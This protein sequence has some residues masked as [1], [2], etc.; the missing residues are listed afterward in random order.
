MRQVLLALGFDEKR[1][2]DFRL[3]HKLVQHA[4]LTDAGIRTPRSEPLLPLIDSSSDSSDL[5]WRI[6][7]RYPR[8]YLVK[9]AVGDGSGERGQI[10]LR[11][12]VFRRFGAPGLEDLI[13][14]ERIRIA[15]EYRVHTMEDQVIAPLVM[16]RYGGKLPPEGATTEVA[17]FVS[18]CLDRL[19]DALVAGSLCGWDVASTAEGW[20]V[21]EVNQTGM[22]P[23]C[24]PRYH[25]SGFLQ[26]PPG[27]SNNL[28]MLLDW[29]EKSYDVR[30]RVC[31]GHPL[32]DSVLMHRR[33]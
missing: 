4:L 21:I 14:Q 7:E 2:F 24:P 18:Q 8:G 15:A 22:A 32:L 31:P 16:S 5:W 11:H 27:G 3:D 28:A 1:V 12:L 26:D 6:R 33:N 10:D 17:A 9:R 25:T 13:V 23:E 20:C 29:I 30:I 19:P